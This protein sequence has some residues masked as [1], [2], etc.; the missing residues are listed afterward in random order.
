MAL[1]LHYTSSATGLSGYPGFQFVAVS[2]GLPP[3]V[4]YIVAQYLSYQLPPSAPPL[5]NKEEM[6]KLP[7]AF[8]YDPSDYG[9][10]LACCRYLGRDYSGRPGNFFGHAVLAKQSELDGLRPIEFWRAPWWANQPSLDQPD[11]ALPALTLTTSHLAVEPNRVLREISARDEAVALLSVIVEMALRGLD[12]PE[13][14]VILVAEDP[15]RIV[16]WIAAISYSLP[17]WLVARLSFVTF[18]AAPGDVPYRLV[19]TN[20]TVWREGNWP[21]SAFDLDALRMPEEC[22][23]PGRLAIAVAQAWRNSDLLRIDAISE[24][25]EALR[26]ASGNPIMGAA[27][28]DC[29]TAAI[30]AQMCAGEALS[31]ADAQM[32]IDVLEHSPRRLPNRVWLALTDDVI[33]DYDLEL[34]AWRAAG[35]IGRYEEASRIGVRCIRRALQDPMDRQRLRSP[36]PLQGQ[37]Q[38]EASKL[39]CD[40]LLSARDLRDVAE[41]AWVSAI[42]QVPVKPDDVQ[43]AALAAVSDE[44]VD[45]E[46]A[47]ATV[48]GEYADC[49]I[50]GALAGLE[51]VSEPTRRINLTSEAC[52]RLDDRDWS[53]WPRV[54]II[55]LADI[56]RREAFRRLSLTVQLLRLSQQLSSTSEDIDALL[57]DVWRDL[58]SAMERRQL[59]GEIPSFQSYN[60]RYALLC[61]VARPWDRITVRQPAEYEIAC[62]VLGLNKKDNFSTVVPDAWLIKALHEI[63]KGSMQQR[64]E[65]VYQVDRYLQEGSP[66][67]AIGVADGIATAL[68]GFPP[69][70]QADLVAQRPQSQISNALRALWLDERRKDSVAIANLAE[71]AVYLQRR[72]SADSAALVLQ[73]GQLNSEP[74]ASKRV[75]K[76]LDKRDKAL[77][78]DFRQMMGQQIDRQ[79]RS[80]SGGWVRSKFGNGL[81]MN[82]YR[83]QS[84]EDAT[85]RQRT[86]KG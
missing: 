21:G 30:L 32:A 75:L 69:S 12:H 71:V 9:P 76:I 6:A 84:D 5:P 49:L 47:L 50:R 64:I 2:S 66:E 81:L 77:A 65:R 10:V 29:E 61:F 74:G 80:D 54:G 63:W 53:L 8:S 85:T 51:S 55:V 23:E 15:E 78:R 28:V 38:S 48:P 68:M 60:A 17:Y 52:R 18:T 72:G 58:P 7:I 79:S 16:T 26:P 25:A 86:D 3:G 70:I 46:D 31:V 40:A 45:V 24:I 1:Q 14:R 62:R 33:Q 42:A 36:G 59:L 41:I 13:A 39:V 37:A 44:T 83:R 56:A 20:Q 19:G 67:V 73:L 35:H 27:I 43:A 22:P 11:N 57:R 82:K 34:A 4:E